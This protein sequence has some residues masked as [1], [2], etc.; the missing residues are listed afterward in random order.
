MPFISFIH[1][2]QRSRMDRAKPL[3]TLPA[4]EAQE[5]RKILTEIPQ[6]I[7]WNTH[8]E[9]K[10]FYEAIKTGEWEP[11]EEWMEEIVTYLL[12]YIAD[13][14]SADELLQDYATQVINTMSDWALPH[15]P[16]YLKQTILAFGQALK[17]S[18]EQ[19]GL[20]RY[21]GALLYKFHAFMDFDIVLVPLD[22][23]EIPWVESHQPGE[24]G[25]R[26]V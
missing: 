22:E 7:I 21:K 18:L 24:P 17:A 5:V 25:W 11:D 4:L 6:K 12:E 14:P 20:Y 2:Q 26:A 16:E 19:C 23:S 15:E 13:Q 10:A 1:F 8:V 3:P 9:L